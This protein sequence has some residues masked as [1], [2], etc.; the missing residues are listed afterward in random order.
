[1]DRYAVGLSSSRAT[2][3][4]GCARRVEERSRAGYGYEQCLL[5]TTGYQGDGRDDS[6]A[7]RSRP[8]PDLDNLSHACILDGTFLR[9]GVPASAPSPLLN[10]Q[11]GEGR[12]GRC[13]KT[14]NAR[15]RSS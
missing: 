15:T 7:R 5:F 11:L 10:S 8:G 3:D 6:G 14:R 12:R 1:V 9:G 13:L 2:G 4:D